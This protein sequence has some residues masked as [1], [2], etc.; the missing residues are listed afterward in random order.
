MGAG[1]GLPP[2]YAVADLAADLAR[3]LD[4]LGIRS[5][6]VLGYSNGGTVAQQLALDE[7]ERCTRLVLACTYAFNMATPQEWVEGHLGPLLIRFLGM[8]RLAN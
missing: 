2:P 4:H 1:R 5:A 7:P 6:A 8:P 3:L